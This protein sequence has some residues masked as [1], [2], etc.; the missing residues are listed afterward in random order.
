MTCCIWLHRKN[1]HEKLTKRISS[2]AYYSCTVHLNEYESNFDCQHF[3]RNRNL[4]VYLFSYPFESHSSRCGSTVPL[5]SILTL[6][7]LH[8][9]LKMHS[10]RIDLCVRGP[11]SATIR[12]H[13]PCLGK[14]VSRSI[15]EMRIHTT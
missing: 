4:H 8:F 15:L 11:V 7:N 13:S 2:M 9:T 1:R 14:I 3:S 5:H 6:S 12:L 10:Y